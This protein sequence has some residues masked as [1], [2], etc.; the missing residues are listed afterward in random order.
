MV[1]IARNKRP[2]SLSHGRPPTIQKPI[3]SLSARATRTLIRSHHQLHKK[4]ARALADGNEQEV[5][6]LDKKIEALGGLKSYQLASKTG[7]SKDRGGDSSKVLIEWLKPALDGLTN[8]ETRLRLLEVGALSARNACS[9]VSCI[10]VVRI[11]LHSQ[12]PGILEQDF[13][14]RPIPS[15]D[16][17]KFHIISLS[18]VLNYV[19]DAT[20]R[21]DMLRHTS[22]FLTSTLPTSNGSLRKLA[23]CLFL[24]LPAACV[25]NSRYFTE[26][27]L[28]DMMSSL[29]FSII[30]R[31]LT[32]KLIYQLWKYNRPANPKSGG[33]EKKMVNPGAKRNN[34]TV[35]L[36]P[37]E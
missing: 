33:F 5:H 37:A 25:L 10:D 31:K 20:T 16:A 15:T 2:K 34:F 1:K 24:V 4:R 35:I 9:A 21:G 27:R 7:Q 14:E 22:A 23:P 11:D 6:E 29:G 26:E 30:R 17:D 3:A 8:C 18:L 13:M 36:T 32:Q 12:E 28:Q 19:P